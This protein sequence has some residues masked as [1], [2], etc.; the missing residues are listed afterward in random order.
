MSRF[1][2]VEEKQ[3][4]DQFGLS[5]VRHLV[6]DGDIEKGGSIIAICPDRDSAVYVQT[7][8]EMMHEHQESLPPPV[9]P[10]VRTGGEMHA[11]GTAITALP[12]CEVPAYSDQVMGRPRPTNPWLE[13]E[14]MS[15]L[16]KTSWRDW[17][18]AMLSNPDHKF[19]KEKDHSYNGPNDLCSKCA[20]DGLPF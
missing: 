2:A 10:P 4:V 20:W 1:D 13:T 3:G 15:W 5:L 11:Y 14:Y 19:C 7:A 8:L 12:V 17:Q 16:S 6:R 18:A 9:Q